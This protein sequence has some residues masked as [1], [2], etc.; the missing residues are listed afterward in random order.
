MTTAITLPKSAS[1]VSA[2]SRFDPKLLLKLFAGLEA[3]FRGVQSDSLEDDADEEFAAERLRE[4]TRLGDQVDGY[5]EEL[6]R[7]HL[8]ALKTL[9]QLVAP[10]KN[11]VGLGVGAY[12]G[13]IEEYRVRKAKLRARS[14]SA[15]RNAAGSGQSRALTTALNTAEQNKAQKLDGVGAKLEWQIDKIENHLAVPR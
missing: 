6:A 12:A 5:Y 11:L 1:T 3:E 2:S 13:A 10:F 8:D 7:S 4:V 9:R 14:L 15:A